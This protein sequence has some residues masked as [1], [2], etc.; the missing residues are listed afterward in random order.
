MHSLCKDGIT[1]LFVLVDNSLVKRTG[2]GRPGLTK[3]EVVTILL[4]NVL[5]ENQQILKDIH[6]WIK[7]YYRAEF[8]DLPGYSAFVDQCHQA[9][10]E[11]QHLLHLLLASDA[12]IRWLDSTMVPVCKSHR[13]KSYKVARKVVGWG[14]N[15]QGFWFGFKLHGSINEFGRFCA[16]ALTSADVYDGHM[17]KNLTNNQTVI[18]VGDSHYGGRA[19]TEPLR[20]KNG[21]IFLAYPH[22]KQNKKLLAGW[23]KMVLNWRSKIESVWDQLKEHMHLVTSF[24][25]SP[26]GYLVHYL[27]IIIGYQL[28][29]M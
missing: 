13:A 9:T 12:P 2:P 21:T 5:T 26:Q 1:D 22:P 11:L 24:P 25:R 3:S 18:A 14:K 10:K 27:P 8:P 20:E 23:Q 17:S 16:V 28:T 19:Q 7:R 6:A 29:V 4:W 15:H